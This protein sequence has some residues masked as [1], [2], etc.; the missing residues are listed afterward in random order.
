MSTQVPDPGEFARPLGQRAKRGQSRGEFGSIRVV[1]GLD[2][3]VA[4]HGQRRILG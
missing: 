3:P 2:D 1:D 4:V